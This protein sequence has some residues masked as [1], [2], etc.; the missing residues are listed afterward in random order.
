M[1]EVGY[2]LFV[3]GGTEEIGAVREVFP[4]GRPEIVV[5]IENAG[6]FI[7]PLSAIESVIEQ[8]VILTPSRLDRH[9][10]EAIRHAHEAELPPSLEG[11]PPEQG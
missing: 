4:A 9:Q 1:I 2:H 7:I 6:D 3:S 8:K 5:D 10:R 11:T